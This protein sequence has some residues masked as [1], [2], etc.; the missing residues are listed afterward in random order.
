MTSSKARLVI[1]GALFVCWLSFLFYLVL[2][3]RHPVISRPQF[4][5]AQAV[6]VVDIKGT[7]DAPNPNVLV[8]EVLWSSDPAMK[9]LGGQKLPVPDL[10]GCGRD[11]GYAGPGEYVL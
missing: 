11:Q 6:V 8:R 7:D 4:M 10:T 2:H 5:I 1:S 9:Q 3:T